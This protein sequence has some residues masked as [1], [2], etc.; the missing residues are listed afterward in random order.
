MKRME[1]TPFF[2]I[3]VPVYNMES[4]M[5]DCIASIKAQTFTDY[6][7]I[8]VDDGSKDGS[9]EMLLGFAKEDSR[10]SVFRHEGNR[11]LLCAR[12]TG[13]ANARGRYILFLDSDD[14]IVPDT[15]ET[16]WRHITECPTDIIRFGVYTDPGG[17]QLLPPKSDDYYRDFITGKISP[18]IVQ[19]CVS[20]RIAKMAVKEIT[21][22]YCNSGEDTFMTGTLYSYA[23]SFSKIDRCF[24]CYRIVGGMSRNKESLS[25]A[26][27]ERILESLDNCT[28]NL[29]AF[30]EKHR[31]AYLDDCVRQCAVMYRYEMCHFILNADDER[32]AVDFLTRFGADPHCLD[33]DYGCRE[34][35]REFFKRRLGA[36]PEDRANFNMF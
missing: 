25:M 19:N 17:I 11:S 1:Q 21:P 6:E 10:Y 22:F 26:K 12:Y 14:T 7:V 31:P 28:E 24:Y 29:T 20:A 32:M 13:M 18:G 36:G 34:V 8:L 16:L 23:E 2:S 9:Y 15:L 30:T 35:L 3:L 5:D 33:Y 4:R 27:L